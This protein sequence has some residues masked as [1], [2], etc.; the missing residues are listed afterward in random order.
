MPERPGFLEYLNKQSY[1]I[2]ML[3]AD[4]SHLTLSFIDVANGMKL[5]EVTLSRPIRPFT[6][7]DHGPYFGVSVM[8]VL[9]T[10]FLFAFTSPYCCPSLSKKVCARMGRP[11]LVS[12]RCSSLN[13]ESNSPTTEMVSLLPSD[14]SKR[15][16]TGSNNVAV[17]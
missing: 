5:D 12:L 3:D 1:G 11:R 6:S 10:I 8:W 4:H 14:A 17:V 2:T 9:L 7:A 13:K 15:Y 16:R